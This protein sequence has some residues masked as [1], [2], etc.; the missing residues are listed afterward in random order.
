MGPAGVTVTVIRDDLIGKHRADTP[1]MC[2]W[3]TFNKAPNTYYNTPV[4]YSIYVAGLNIAHMK[5]NGLK[6][7]EDEA[8]RK[9][10]LLYDFIDGSNDYYSNPIDKK[11]RSRLNIPFRVKKDE[12]LETKFL[13]E[14]AKHGLVELKGHRTVGGCRASIY[15]AMPYEGVEALIN[16]MKQF[17]DENHWIG[18][19]GKA[20]KSKDDLAKMWREE[21]CI[22][23]S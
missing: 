21:V 20:L 1:I 5:K 23:M 16:F 19:V 13:A 14:A 2:D 8:Q 17:M 22:K 15:N 9:S 4:C 18:D 12:A 3:S 11:Y 7:Y 6:Y 10:K